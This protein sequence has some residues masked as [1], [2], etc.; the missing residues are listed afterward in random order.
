MLA[1]LEVRRIQRALR[2]QAPFVARSE[3]ICGMEKWLV[4]HCEQRTPAKSDRQ[5]DHKKSI[6]NLSSRIIDIGNSITRAARMCE[7][8]TQYC[9]HFSR[10]PYYGTEGLK[11]E[12]WQSP[13]V[14]G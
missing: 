7:K 9:S 1:P 8:K 11:V 2:E 14:S 5:N 13:F 3:R 10:A 6:H 12:S 4:F